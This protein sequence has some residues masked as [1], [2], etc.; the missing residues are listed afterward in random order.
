MSVTPL[1]GITNQLFLSASQAKVGMANP[2]GVISLSHEIGGSVKLRAAGMVA[3]AGT[4][5]L[6]MT[7]AGGATL[8]GGPLSK[9]SVLPAEVTAACGP[10]SM[11]TTASG[12]MLTAPGGKCVV[13]TAAGVIIAGPLIRLG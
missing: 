1:A 8:T 5:K 13:A 9:V 4:S 6:D 2:D 3:E 10:S 7:L 12:G 11:A